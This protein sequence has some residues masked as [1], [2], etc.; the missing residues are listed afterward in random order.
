MLAACVLSFRLPII[1]KIVAPLPDASD[2]PN[3]NLEPVAKE[4]QLAPL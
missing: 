4:D 2:V 3:Q 1:A